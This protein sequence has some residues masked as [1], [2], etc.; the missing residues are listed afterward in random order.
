MKASERREKILQFFRERSGPVSASVLAA[1]FDVSRQI[2]VGDVALL[3]A[4]GA[5]IAATPRGYVFHE[6]AE[7][8][9]LCQVACVH[10]SAHMEEELQV[11]VDMGCSVENVIVEHPVYGQLTGELQLHSRYDVQQFME[12]V[13]AQSA[14]SLS[15]LTDGIHI[16]TLRCPGEE[17]FIRV[18]KELK[19]KGFLLDE[20]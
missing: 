13:R 11:C 15:E 17:A 2:I 12:K 7:S 6:E 1:H 9:M 16:H 8:G 14:H 19:Q 3:R 5:Q 4:Q 18:C 20:E 10:D